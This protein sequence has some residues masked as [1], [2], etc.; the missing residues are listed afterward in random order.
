MRVASFASLWHIITRV[1]SLDTL[2]TSRASPIAF[3]F[4][5]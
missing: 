4:S 2:T 5:G 3:E 1:G